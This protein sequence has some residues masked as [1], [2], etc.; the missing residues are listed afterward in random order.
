MRSNAPLVPGSYPGQSPPVFSLARPLWGVT[1]KHV[2]MPQFAVWKHMTMGRKHHSRMTRALAAVFPNSKFVYFTSAFWAK[3]FSQ[4]TL[5]SGLRECHFFQPIFQEK[6]YIFLSAIKLLSKTAKSILDS[7]RAM[8]Q[9]QNV[10]LQKKENL[11][12]HSPWLGHC[13]TFWRYLRV[14][15]FFI[16]LVDALEFFQLPS[17]PLSQDVFSFKVALWNIW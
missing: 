7:A 9:L 10:G 5:P 17:S 13:E 1:S 16:A 4:L 2:I 6:K 11:A 14:K 8:G 3:H 15:A 12:C